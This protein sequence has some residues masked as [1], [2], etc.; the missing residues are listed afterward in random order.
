MFKRMRSQVLTSIVVIAMVFSLVPAIQVQEAKAS[1]ILNVHVAVNATD[2]AA[3]SCDDIEGANYELY[4]AESRFANYE[5][6]S[7][8]NDNNFFVSHYSGSYYY[9]RAIKDDKEVAKS[10]IFSEEIELFG[11]NTYIFEDTDPVNKIQNVIDTAYK[12]TEAGQ[13]GKDR[14]AFMFKPSGTEYNVKAKVGFYTQVAGLGLVPDNVKVKQIECLAEWMKGWK[15]ENGKQVP[16]YN[17]L[18]NFWRSVENVSSSA[19]ATTWAVSQATAMRKVHLNG[20]LNLHE[21]GGYASGGF[22]ADS[23]VGTFVSSGS[24]QQWLSRNVQTNANNDSRFKD[25]NYQP[26]VWNNVL[27]GCKTHYTE[28]DWPYGTTTNVDKTPRIAEKPYI[29]YDDNE[30]KIIV[31]KVKEN[32]KGVSWDSYDAGTDYR[33]IRMKKSD[34]YTAKPGDT[35]QDINSAIAA[36]GIKAL[37]L[38]PG[39]YEL[40]QAIVIN[41]DDFVVLGLGYATLKPTNANECMCVRD[42]VKGVRLAGMLFDAGS[43]KSSDLLRVGEIKDNNNNSD[44]PIVISDCFFRVGGADSA[45]CQV[46]NC[47]EITA[48]DVITD[49]FWVWRADHGSGVGWYKNTADNGVTFNGDRIT[50]YGLMVEHFQKNQTIWNG[51]GGRTYMYQ[52]ELP[53]DIPNQKSWNEKGSYGYTDYVVSKGVTSHE[54]YGIGIYSCY[55]AAQ[56]FEKSAVTCPDAPN[57]KFTNVLTYSL[58]GNG[59]IDYVINKAGYGV[60]G[61]SETARILSYANGKA[62]AD[63]E[64]SAAKKTIWS[65]SYD[66]EIPNQTYTGKAI[67]PIKKLVYKGVTLRSGVDYK[68][69]YKNNVKIGK[70]SLKIQGL[71]NFKE[72]D[73]ITFKIVPG[74]TKITKA[75]GT[76]KKIKIK[77]KKVKGAGGYEV[78]WAKK[79]SFKG[80]KVKKTKKL[81][82]TIKRKDKKRKKYYVRVRAYKK[83]GKKY[84]YGKFSKKKK[85]A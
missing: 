27:V 53:Y 29:A 81:K 73:D 77:Y 17:A 48:N 19:D 68:M 35:A 80:K 28:S 65:C 33:T 79:K 59:G 61:A 14:Y 72:I 83:V 70:A 54:G 6:K 8:Y 51:N 38:S 12:T 22:L 37:V 41:K 42:N 60:Y 31:P 30:Y 18:C 9:I 50:A 7:T 5:K 43:K 13:F 52:S 76:K 56:C 85:V 1:D 45:N 40:D 75:K 58:V 36:D 71:G 3:I 24:Q 66:P 26:A 63:K 10:K 11:E 15:W 20:V 34:V 74:K 4:V 55:Q 21:N 67:Q 57:V 46:E 16:N 78:Q 44:N 2:L 23:K 25:W 49:N 39:I 64:G 32:T 47:V 69:T 62:K 84:Y 82:Y